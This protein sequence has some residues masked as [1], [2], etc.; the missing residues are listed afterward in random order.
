VTRELIG[1]N[2]IYH[3]VQ[4][5]GE[6]VLLLHGGFCSIETMR[7]QMDALTTRYTVYAP[8][9][10]GHGRS[11]DVAGPFTYAQSV[12]DTLAYLDHVGVDRAHL[13]GFSDGAI[14]GL[15]IAIQYPERVRSLVAISGNLD[16]SAFTFDELSQGDATERHDAA[17]EVQDERIDGN[18]GTA[19]AVETSD[20]NTDITDGSTATAGA[21]RDRTHQLY[22]ELS[23]DGPEHAGVILSKL[24]RLWT[25]EPHIAPEELSRVA[26][27]TMI[28]AGDQDVIAP[29]H[30]RL[31]AFSI[32]AGE[33]C[34]V[35]GAGHDL[36]ERRPDFVTC[37][38][39]D[40]LITS[41]SG[42]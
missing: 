38:I 9:R 39:Q 16:P 25:N 2:D 29:E 7:P 32:P 14:I 36:L 13:V 24:E 5:A 3:E 10:P 30:S 28:M 22:D 34:I 33:L 20:G 11:P 23:P 4:G 15:M 37:A 19:D 40:F 21:P 42:S 1:G 17:S 18:A 41:A 26:A 31:M 8:E 35:P 6:P 12:A 27:P